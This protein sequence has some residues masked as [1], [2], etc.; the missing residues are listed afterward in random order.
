M[1]RQLPLLFA[2]GFYVGLIPG[3]PGTYASILTAVA[4]YLLHVSSG[5][6]PHRYHFGALCLITLGGIWAASR[7]SW[8]RGDK[9][10]Q[11]V[12]IDEIVGQAATFLWLPA[13]GFNLILGVVLF[14][15][16]DIL[17]PFPIRRLE[18]LRGGV[19][20]IADDLMAAVY[21]NL[22]LQIVG[23]FLG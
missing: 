18:H 20:I 12:V 11:I 8:D 13:S 2:T 15:F 22:I 7:V 3:A 9:D 4:F 10:P 5:G 14:R 17:K 23:L 6:I 21:A 16:F 1:K 19:G